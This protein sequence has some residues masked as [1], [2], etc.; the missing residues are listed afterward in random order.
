[1]IGAV[2]LRRRW[3]VDIEIN[4]KEMGCE[5]VHWLPY[6]RVTNFWVP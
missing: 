4:P 2:V 5:V 3:E 1:L 6:D